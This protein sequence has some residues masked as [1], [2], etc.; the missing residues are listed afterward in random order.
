MNFALLSDGKSC[1][2]GWG[3]CERSSEPLKNAFYINDFDLADAQPWCRFENFKRLD[4]GQVTPSE[5]PLAEL[6]AELPLSQN[7]FLSDYE[8]FREDFQ[9]AVQAFQAGDFR[10]VLLSTCDWADREKETLSSKI[11]SLP[12]LPYFFYAYNFEGKGVWGLSPELLL[13]HDAA[14]KT[15]KTV[16]LAGTYT[17]TTEERHEPEH[18]AVLD[19]FRDLATGYDSLIHFNKIVPSSYGKIKHLK[20]E[21]LLEKIPDKNLN[22]WIRAFHPTPA[23]GV[24]PRNSSTMKKLKDFRK[25]LPSHFG[26]PMGF[27]SDG[28]SKFIVMIR[29]VFFDQERLY[30]PIGVGVTSASNIEAEWK[31]ISLKRLAMEDIWKQLT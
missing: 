14:K 26:A 28:T 11:Q 21:I 12:A 19:F 6:F 17:Q 23:L 27:R 13:E 20:S 25:G 30:R 8:V 22:E 15:L 1:V 5:V 31:E 2:L 29:G 16:A 24:S 3:A 9:E 7:W 4:V 18:N 10:K